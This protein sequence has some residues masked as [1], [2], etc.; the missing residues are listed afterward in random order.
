[1]KNWKVELKKIGDTGN[2]GTAASALADWCRLVT[3][4]LPVGTRQD[5]FV[6]PLRLGV[7][8]ALLLLCL[9]AS[10]AQSYSIDWWTIDGGGGTSTGGV[11][12]VTGT[13]GQPD[14]GST[15]MT[16]GAYSVTGGF[17]ALAAVQTPGAP[18]LSIARTAT[19]TVAVWWAS[20][21][22]GWILQQNTNSV[23][24]VNWS[25]VVTAPV[26]DG[27]NKMVIISS[28]TGN[29]FYRLFKP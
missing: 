4:L 11:Y 18:L 24:S 28:P 2:S 21:S 6:Q 7:A 27:T 9:S 3:H 10:F 29:R 16:G 14:A 23:T 1:M 15:A 19:D 25:N 12:A 20:P 13:I 17:W 8:V 26:D 5:W 22:T